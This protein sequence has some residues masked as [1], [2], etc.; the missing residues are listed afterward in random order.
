MLKVG[1]NG[2]GRIGRA[3][4]RINH[5]RSRFQVVCINDI[6]PNSENHAYLLKFDSVYGRFSVR[7]SGNNEYAHMTVDGEQIKLYSYQDCLEV[8]WSDHQ[9]DVV[10]DASGVYENVLSGR[11][12]V[13]GGSTVS[14]VVVTHSPRTGVDQTLVMGLNEASYDPNSHH[15]LS[16]SICD[17][18]ACGPILSI[19]DREFGI[20]HGF[21]TTLHPWL[22]YQNLVDGSV[23]SVSNPGHFWEDFSLGEAEEEEDTAGRRVSSVFRAGRR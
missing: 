19:L 1:I 18:N 8:P 6:D 23:R 22:S 20:A 2:F 11:N 4:F 10:I 9:V 21:I 15:V 13:S 14:K 3:I 12:L 5:E 7:A 16:T 17:A